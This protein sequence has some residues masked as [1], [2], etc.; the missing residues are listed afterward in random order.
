MCVAGNCRNKAFPEMPE[1]SSIAKAFPEMS[2][3]L[4]NKISTVIIL[5][6]FKIWEMA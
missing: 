1:F 6:M 2:R 4:Q 5:T 3:Q